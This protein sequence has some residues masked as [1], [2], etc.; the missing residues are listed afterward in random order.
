MS[1][2]D[3]CCL[4]VRIR[5]QYMAIRNIVGV[6]TTLKMITNKCIKSTTI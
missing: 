1:K 3:T 6:T 2:N 4:C 5:D